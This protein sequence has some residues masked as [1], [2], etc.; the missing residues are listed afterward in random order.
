MKSIVREPGAY[1]IV[2]AIAVLA[3]CLPPP[4]EPAKPPKAFVP[5][6]ERTG[7]RRDHAFAKDDAT[8]VCPAKVVAGPDGCVGGKHLAKNEPINLGDDVEATD[9]F[10]ETWLPG[11]VVDLGRGTKQYNLIKAYVAV[12][13][14]VEHRDLSTYAAAA[15]AMRANV[16][17]DSSL[18]GI[19][20]NL[21]ALLANWQRL[22]GKRAYIT[23]IGGMNDGI[24][25]QPEPAT[26]RRAD[27]VRIMSRIAPTPT[28]SSGSAPIA[29]ELR[30]EA[31][32]AHYRAKEFH[33][34]CIATCDE[35][36]MIVR[37]APEP[38]HLVDDHGRAYVV[39]LMIVEQYADRSWTWLAGS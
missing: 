22:V 18:K 9:G 24:A 25:L 37:V 29:Y 21:Q 33:L 36:S 4:A 31:A 27:R 19:D 8:W 10:Y 12:G 38:L 1:S 11:A 32:V 30:G 26:H 15:A 13:S 7:V 14:V 35:A 3:G 39:P 2:T 20:Y 34:D 23:I 16:P 17:K 28:S 5:Y 6:S